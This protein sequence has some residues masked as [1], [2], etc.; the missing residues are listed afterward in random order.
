MA[1]TWIRG[2]WMRATRARN[3]CC[4]CALG[5]L[6]TGVAGA[7]DSDSN[8]ALSGGDWRGQM[9]YRLEN[10]DIDGP[11]RTATAST[12]RTRL[13]FE[14][15]TALPIGA[16]VEVEDVHALGA[17]K[18]NSTTNGRNDYAVVAD[19]DST[20][21]NQAY[22]T[23]RGRGM[24]ANVG[25]QTLSF[26]GERF[27]GSVDFRQNQQT[28]DSV[29]AQGSLSNGSQLTYAYLWQVNRFLGDDHPLGNLD[30]RTH[31]VNFA[32]P[33]LNG[34]RF[35]AYTYLL[36]FDELTAA[37]TKTFGAS[38]DGGI[39]VGA[40]KFLYRA[41]YAYQSDYADNPHSASV[42]YANA[43]LGIRFVAQW[44]VTAGVE[45]LNGDGAAAFQTPLATLHKFNGFADIFA[46]ATPPGG[47]QD[48]YLRLYAPILGT[49]LTVT[50]HDFR[51]DDGDRDY[52]R[53]IDAEL[54][55]RIDS[56]WL[57]GLKYADYRDDTFAAD[58]R[59][60]WLWVQADF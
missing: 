45:V 53:E 25:R 4:G 15:N 8:G 57:I 11:L 58:T 1:T 56:H 48:R 31:A 55:W 17:E 54:N 5:L 2:T 43:E 29:F 16:L 10:V 40:R 46:G 59:K 37:S 28:Y 14:T 38:Y 9:R 7:Q 52:G 36:E 18:F 21:L 30:M 22:L 51:D 50:A 13:G 39:D 49:R 26:D 33:R 60:G 24:R 20:E 19:P 44:V 34:D 3:A 23:A 42:W 35:V 32:F 6:A 47:L 41:E 12:L 27:I